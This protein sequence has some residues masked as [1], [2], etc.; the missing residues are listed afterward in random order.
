MEQEP[1]FVEMNSRNQGETLSEIFSRS[2]TELATAV[3]DW[4]DVGSVEEYEAETTIWSS[5]FARPIQNF[6]GCVIEI[7][8][9]KEL[10]LG[11]EGDMLDWLHLEW[12][13]VSFEWIILVDFEWA[14]KKTTDFQ[15]FLLR[16]SPTE[17][18]FN[19]SYLVRDR[20]KA[21]LKGVR[22]LEKGDWQ[23]QFSE[24]DVEDGPKP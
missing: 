5:D 18:N 14:T 11:G 15:S 9:P 3:N 10:R 12:E 21:D 16:F 20:K 23:Y 1:E 13:R 8:G 7:A 2:W 4:S 6:V 17:Q 24:K 19:L 22:S